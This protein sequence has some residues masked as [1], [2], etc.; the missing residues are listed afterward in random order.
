MQFD[1]KEIQKV[2]KQLEKLSLI[3]QGKVLSSINRKAIKPIVDEMKAN[4]PNQEIADDIKA[5]KDKGDITGY[6]GGPSTDSYVARFIEF[7]TKV[8][9][10]RG[11]IEPKPFIRPAIQKHV[12]QLINE[13]PKTYADNWE[14]TIKKYLK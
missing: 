5:R 7:G 4:A 9:E 2:L 1:D 10:K 12:Q 3:D 13:L 8:R 6:T 14:K 11:K